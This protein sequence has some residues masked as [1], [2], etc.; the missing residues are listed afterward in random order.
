MNRVF[1]VV[2]LFSISLFANPYTSL[3]PKVQ[4]SIMINHFVTKEVEALLPPRPQKDKYKQEDVDLN[5]G[6]YERY[7]NYIERLRAIERSKKSE[8]KKIQEKFRGQAGYYNGK[9]HA[10]QKEYQDL[11]NLSPLLQKAINNGFKVVYGKPYVT[12]YSNKE[13][14]VEA[15]LKATKI[16][17]LDNKLDLEI[18]FDKKIADIHHYRKYPA[19]VHFNYDGENL[20]IEGIEIVIDNQ[21]YTAKLKNENN[22][23]IKLKVKINDDIFQKINLEDNK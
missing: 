23:K 5:P 21:T 22:G 11:K 15:K 3:D 16:Y 8:L 1:L 12:G 17:H 4:L 10:I 13:E 19:L 2:V 9:L 14:R 7:Y 6:Q 20:S 18:V